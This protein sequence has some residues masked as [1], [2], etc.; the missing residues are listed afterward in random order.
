[1]VARLQARLSRSLSV[2]AFTGLV[3]GCFGAG[4]SDRTSP[5]LEPTGT[6]AVLDFEIENVVYDL[7][8]DGVYATNVEGG[9]EVHQL[10]EDGSVR[11]LASHEAQFDR[12]THL[13]SR[14]D[15]Q[16][17]LAAWERLYVFDGSTM[18]D[19]TERLMNTIIVANPTNLVEVRGLDMAEDGRLYIAVSV[20]GQGDAAPYGQICTLSASSEGD[21][22]EGLDHLDSTD[23]FGAAAV[24]VEGERTYVLGE[25]SLFVREGNGEFG[26]ANTHTVYGIYSLDDGRVG[27]F[28]ADESGAWGLHVIGANGAEEQVIAKLPGSTLYGHSLERLWAVEVATDR[29]TSDCTFSISSCPTPLRRAQLMVYR[30]GEEHV[31]IGH[32]D[33][34]PG[35]E[36]LDYA[37]LARPDGSLHL[38]VADSVYHIDAP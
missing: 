25:E 19:W 38:E 7:R 5:V 12:V 22:C 31:E 35:G 26:F 27:Y 21:H 9:W 11:V 8:R 24:I 10:A 15:S 14:S 6:D 18:A 4:L 32:L 17:A 34:E 13:V 3:S 23:L 2:L 29:D 36:L 33:R 37:A 28:R 20:G 30:V 1:M 16:L